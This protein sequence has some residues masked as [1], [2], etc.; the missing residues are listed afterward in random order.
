MENRNPTFENGS[1]A[2]ALKVPNG[3]LDD[4]TIMD[5]TMG[6]VHV[7]VTGESPNII[8]ISVSDGHQSKEGSFELEPLPS[9]ALIFVSWSENGFS[10]NIDDLDLEILTETE[11]DE[12]REALEREITQAI[13]NRRENLENKDLS[14]KRTYAE[15]LLALRSRIKSGK[16]LISL[17]DDGEIEHIPALSSWLRTLICRGRGRN[18]NPL[19]QQFGARRGIFLPVYSTYSNEEMNGDIVPEKHVFSMLKSGISSSVGPETP[20]LMDIDVWLHQR[21]IAIRGKTITNNDF[22]RSHSDSEASHFD[23][24]T[25]DV[26]ELLSKTNHLNRDRFKNDMDRFIVGVSKAVVDLGE[27]VLDNSPVWRGLSASRR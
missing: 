2:V 12:I 21:G 10:I 26:V 14:K 15:L 13:E 4:A 6:A 16:R 27:F 1:I 23:E 18:M 5:T 25:N 17:I 22:I 11:M 9:D 8:K 20:H 24:E 3:V 19:L 7:V